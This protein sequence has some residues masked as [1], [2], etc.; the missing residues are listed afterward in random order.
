MA[1]KKLTPLQ[2]RFVE[3]YLISL[4]ATDAA[5]KA[6]Y[7]K[8]TANKKGPELLQYPLVAKKIKE[9]LME[10]ESKKIATQKEVL[11]YLTSV[12]RGEETDEILKSVGDFQQDIAELKVNSKDR[13]KAAELLGKYFGTWT[14]KVDMHL[15]MPTIISGEDELKD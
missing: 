2:E 1:K 6:G 4:N 11:T 15:E 9:R 8:K 14:D 13:I 5:K 12:L 10:L 7:S 3:E